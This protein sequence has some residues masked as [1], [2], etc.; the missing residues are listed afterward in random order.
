MLIADFRFNDSYGSAVG[1]PPNL[2]LLGNGT[3]SSEVVDGVQRRVLSFEAGSGLGIP[4]ASS[5]IGDAYTIAMLFKFESTG[6]YR[7]LIDFKNR[8][9]DWGLYSLNGKLNFYSVAMGTRGAIA[10][11]QFVQVVLTRGLDGNVRGFV[12]KVQEIGFNDSGGH[13]LVTAN[14]SLSFFQDD[15]VVRNEHSAGAVARI[16]IWDGPLSEAA[17]ESLDLFA[18]EAPT[19][20]IQ[21][22]DPPAAT[23]GTPVSV[24]GQ[25]LQLVT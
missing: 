3:F 8:T 1:S 4:S 21:G 24:I 13:A 10:P 12:N 15:L 5:G 6:G 17:V 2:E 11:G 19:S 25:N 22:F 16:R 7:R 9:T 14:G 23:P 18:G 20:L